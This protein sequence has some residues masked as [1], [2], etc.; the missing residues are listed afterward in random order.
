MSTTPN[1]PPTRSAATRERLTASAV[2]AFAERGY[3]DARVSDIVAEAG[4]TQPTFYA[5][6]DSKEALFRD[7]IE[8]FRERVRRLVA[9]SADPGRD[10]ALHLRDA[11]RVTCEAIFHA[12]AENPTLTRLALQQAPD[13][14]QVKQDLAAL[15]AEKVRAAQDAGAVRRDVPAALIADSIAG[16]VERLTLRALVTGDVDAATLARFVAELHHDGLA[17]PGGRQA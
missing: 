11:I 14:E 8:R 17:A 15:L 1:R 5:Y 12:F 16:S 7:L 9:D 13:A 10:P 4:V 2:R 6:F 3:A